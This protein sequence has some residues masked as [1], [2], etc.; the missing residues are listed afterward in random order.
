MLT[1]SSHTTTNGRAEDHLNPGAVRRGRGFG[2]LDGGVGRG[3]RCSRSPPTSCPPPAWRT[4]DMAVVWPWLLTRVL[5]RSG[6]VG[7]M[8]VA[9]RVQDAL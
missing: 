5:G 7:S 4:L 3:P 1:L 8:S 2:V 6:S 9:G